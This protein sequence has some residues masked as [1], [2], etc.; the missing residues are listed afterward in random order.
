MEGDGGV[1]GLMEVGVCPSV[2]L[3]LNPAHRPLP[4]PWLRPSPKHCK[5][6]SVQSGL[7]PTV[8][9]MHAL[10]VTPN[11][12]HTEKLSAACLVTARTPTNTSLSNYVRF[13]AGFD[14]NSKL[15]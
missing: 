8:P 1:L 13:G 3:A 14:M 11:W 15:N 5:R 9:A 4:V 2:R 12:R 6:L 7:G 10:W